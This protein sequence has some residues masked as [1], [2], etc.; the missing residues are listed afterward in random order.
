MNKE[1]HLSIIIQWVNKVNAARQRPGTD[2][3]APVDWRMVTVRPLHKYIPFEQQNV[4]ITKAFN[5]ITEKLA[6]YEAPKNTCKPIDANTPLWYLSRNS[7]RK[8]LY[9]ASIRR[10]ISTTN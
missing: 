2:W 4:N 8:A 6:R 9:R 1:K 7:L 10:D 5:Y 3:N